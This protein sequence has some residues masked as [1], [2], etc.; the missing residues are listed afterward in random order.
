[1]PAWKKVLAMLV[2]LLQILIGFL[3]ILHTYYSNLSDLYSWNQWLSDTEEGQL[4]L[5]FS[6]IFIV[7]MGFI[8]LG[9]GLFGPR[10]TNQLVIFKDHTNRLTV[11]RA[12]VE[13]NLIL[14]LSKEYEIANI[15][16]KIRLLK[17]KQAAKVKVTGKLINE[18]DIGTLERKISQTVQ[19]NLEQ[20]LNI[21]LK[22]LTLKLSL[23][24]MGIK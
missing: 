11:D 7:F 6:Q 1:M 5:L 9:V 2:G 22:H 23:T 10:S 21:N 24:V 18:S 20:V 8:F 16:I 14:L 15:D 17:N 19:A 13:K 4:L 12:A 3:V